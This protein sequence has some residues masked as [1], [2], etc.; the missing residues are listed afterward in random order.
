MPHYGNEYEVAISKA[1]AA[2]LLG[3]KQRQVPKIG[4]EVELTFFHGYALKVINVSGSL[5]L[6]CFNLKT[7]YWLDIFKFDPNKLEF[8]H[9]TPQTH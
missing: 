7:E 3:A 6:G 9:G 1:T 2:K 8:T 4:Y 5:Y